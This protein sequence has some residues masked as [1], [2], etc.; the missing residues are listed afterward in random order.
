MLPHFPGLASSS[1]PNFYNS[2]FHHSA[3]RYICPTTNVFKIGERQINTISIP[4]LVW[5]EILSR[6]IAKRVKFESLNPMATV[7]IS[8]MASFFVFVLRG[9]NGKFEQA[10]SWWG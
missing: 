5:F 2:L 4:A 3:E 8:V 6:M 7:L 1:A 10:Q 9:L